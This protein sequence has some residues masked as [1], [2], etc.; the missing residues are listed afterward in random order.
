MFQTFAY[1]LSL[2]YKEFY[3]YAGAGC[4][5]RKKRSGILR[6]LCWQS[7]LAVLRPN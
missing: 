3:A 6:H 7:I 2:L 1:C 4:T 5:L